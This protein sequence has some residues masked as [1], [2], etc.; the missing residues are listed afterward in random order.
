MT[1]WSPFKDD[2][3]HSLFQK[4]VNEGKEANTYPDKGRF[5]L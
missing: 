5:S 2:G 4:L 1:Y 3:I